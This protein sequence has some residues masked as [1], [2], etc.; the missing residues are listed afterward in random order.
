MNL[1]DLHLNTRNLY[2][3]I[4]RSCWLIICIYTAGTLLELLFTAHDHLDFF[5]QATCI[6]VLEMTVLNL[7]MGVV[8]RRITR[9]IEYLLIA[10]VNLFISII[11]I[12]LYE[13]PIVFYILIIPILL[14]LYFY[15]KRL[16]IFALIQAILTVTLIY[17]FSTAIRYALDKSELIMLFSMFTATA[18]I[19]NSLR[20]HAFALTQELVKVTQEKQD[21]QTRNTLMERLNRVD[22]ATGL[23]NHRSFHEHLVNVMGVS[24]AYSLQVHLAI[25]DIDNF[26]KVNDTFGHA[27]GDSV[28]SYVATQLNEF[29]D[30]NDFASRYGGEE[31]AILSV[32]KD[33][34]QFVEQLEAIRLAI[35]QKQF[36]SMNGLSV[37]ISI[38]VQR[39]MPGMNKE[40]LFHQADMALYEAKKSGKNR[41]IV[42]GSHT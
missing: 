21:L 39:L 29:L 9:W 27:V 38:G 36:D 8:F 28:I 34:A 3:D 33:T 6:P 13:L 41:T 40:D 30:Q 17:T 23:Y 25:L 11:I 35:S 15:S 26:K 24:E 37:T 1:N 5:L 19:I 10:G 16:I 42:V 12:S 14:S 2:K 32:E 18:L 22:S 7:I 31:F 20:K 4:L